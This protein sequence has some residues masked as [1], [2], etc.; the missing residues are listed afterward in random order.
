MKDLKEILNENICEFKTKLK[1]KK[2]NK[3]PLNNGFKIS[4]VRDVKQRSRE[5]GQLWPDQASH[6]FTSTTTFWLPSYRDAICMLSKNIR[7]YHLIFPRD[8]FSSF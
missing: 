5:G 2:M 6:A 4:L 7:N 3:K 1:F 8:V